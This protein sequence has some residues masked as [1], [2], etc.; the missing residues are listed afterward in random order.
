ME[1]DLEFIVRRCGSGDET[2]LSLLGRATFLET[3]AGR[4]EAADLLAY[5][6]TEH[7][8]ESY[9]L[10]LANEFAHIWAVETAVGRSAIGYLVALIS[11]NAVSGPEIEI[12]RLYLLYRFHRNGLGQLLMN[13]VLAA[14]RQS[15]VVKFFLKVQDA[16]QSAI[17]FYLHNGFRVVGE[18]PFRAGN[19]DYKVLVMRLAL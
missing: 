5:A 16:N 1:V 8:I 11:P 9:R 10:W 3:Y 17:D 2:A 4:S 6:E 7:S 18:E 15:R 19:R 13:E 12:K 14:A